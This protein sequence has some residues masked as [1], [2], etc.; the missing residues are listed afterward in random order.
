[1]KS[2]ITS[3]LLALT[4]QIESGFAAVSY[5]LSCSG[6]RGRVSVTAYTAAD[7]L[8]VLY[9]NA[10]GAIDFPLYEGVVTRAALTYVKIAEQELSSLDYEVLLSWPINE[11]EFKSTDPLLM[12]CGGSAT[13]HRPENT[14]VKSFS[15]STAHLTEA[16]LD[17]TFNTFRIRWGLMGENFHHFL[18]LPFDPK[19]CQA[20]LKQ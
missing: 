10:L 9:N 20:S 2:F 15:F 17:N 5:Q 6:N 14:P 12:K 13:I 19:H 1:M 16:G 8:Y 18:A 11:C 3:L 7:R 4:F